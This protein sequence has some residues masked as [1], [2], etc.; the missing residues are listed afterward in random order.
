MN[1][2]VSGKMLNKDVAKR[3][4]N[5][6]PA[7]LLAFVLAVSAKGRLYL[8]DFAALVALKTTERDKE[9]HTEKSMLDTNVNAASK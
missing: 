8:V 1:V 3:A 4:F 6:K 9:R 2:D 7:K 5:E